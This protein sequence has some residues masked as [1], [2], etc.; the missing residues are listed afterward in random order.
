MKERKNTEKDNIIW[1]K[2]E[3]QKKIILYERKKKSDIMLIDN[4]VVR[5]Q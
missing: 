4:K 1:K 3:M 5:W 2:E